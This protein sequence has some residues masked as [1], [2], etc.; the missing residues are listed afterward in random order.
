MLYPIA[1][2]GSIIGVNPGVYHTALLYF[3][4][5]FLF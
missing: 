2:I 3:Y 1:F 4:Y 5:V